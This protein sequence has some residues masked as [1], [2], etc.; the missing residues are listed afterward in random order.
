MGANIL[1]IDPAKNVTAVANKDGIETISDFF[2]TSVV[3]VIEKKYG[4]AGIITANN[5]LAHT[6]NIHDIIAAIKKLLDRNGVFVF[7]TQ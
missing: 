7:E 1:G 3:S 2:G 5:V 6:D 4:K